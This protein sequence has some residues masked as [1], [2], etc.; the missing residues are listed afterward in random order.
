MLVLRSEYISTIQSVHQA[1]FNEFGV[2]I[3]VKSEDP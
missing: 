3:S 2:I 1:E